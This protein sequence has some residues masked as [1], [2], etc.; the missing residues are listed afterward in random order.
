VTFT[1]GEQDTANGG[2]LR[3]VGREC[4]VARFRPGRN[5]GIGPRVAEP[6]ATLRVRPDRLRDRARESYTY[7]DRGESEI[8]V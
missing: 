3:Q 4:V 1:S 6:G 5:D 8:P 2:V 7:P